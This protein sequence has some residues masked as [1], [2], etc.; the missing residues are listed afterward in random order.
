MVQK[1]ASLAGDSW[2]GVSAMLVALPSAIAFG[3]TIF[4]PLG[5]SYA[6]RGAIAGI[7]GA[8]ALGLVT[9]A[10]GGASRLIS[11][12]CAPAAAVLSALAIELVRRGTPAESVA[13][14]LAIVALLTGV[15][16]V[17]FGSLGFGR[18]IK[19]MP[20]PVMSGYMSGVGLLIIMAQ[21]PKLL[22]AANG[23][24][25]WAAVTTPAGWHWHG[26]AVGVVTMTVM[27][28]APKITKAM[29]ATIL[30]LLAGVATY[31]VIALT[32][33]SMLSLVGNATVVG[34]LVSGAAGGGGF[35]AGI[36]GRVQAVRT[37]DLTELTTL[38]VPALSLAVLLSIDAL[39][40]CVVVDAI[41]RSRHDSN[42]VLIGQGFGNL[43]STLIGGVP[44][45]GTMG[46]T[47]VN[48]SSGATTRLSGTVEGIA[49]LVA[50]LALGSLLAWIPIAALAGI[51]IVVGARMFDLHALQF[52]KSRST[53]LDFVVIVTVVIVAETVSLIAASGAGI[54]LA[55]LLFIRE[56][57][58]GSVVRRKTYGNQLFS[59][60][61]RLPNEVQVLEQHGDVT[62]ILELQGSLFFGT[63]DQLYTALEPELKARQFLILDMRRVNAVD[64]TA[65]HVLE[66]VDD[67]MKERHAE[68]IFS[69]LPHNLPGGRDVAAYLGHVGFTRRHSVRMFGELDNALEWVEEQVIAEAKLENLQR[70]ALALHEMALFKGRKPETLAELEACL[71]ARTLAAGERI[72]SAGETGDELYL[73]RRGAVRIVLPIG[74]AQAHHVAT[75]RRA[76]FF[77]EMGFLDRAPRSADAVAERETELFVLKR[78]RFD[79]L[80]VQHHRLAMSVFEGIAMALAHRLRHTNMELR[81]LEEA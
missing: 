69:S 48:I 53:I 55:I 66:L 21:L 73:I 61:V 16:Q 29:P 40:T 38:I 31:F 80:A 70:P 77:G 19:Y 58:R 47:L 41:T 68:L 60:Q 44:G 6:A 26:I 22:G 37:L 74:T 2:G 54:G 78:E 52:L 23:A 4:A 30:G 76:D 18:L 51:L 43:A 59:K 5:G 34:P 71:E 25:L 17:A 62:A 67:M 72:F 57:V 8:T 32:D 36:T 28:L 39:K 81:S 64:V 15:L 56:Q 46:P 50:F 1:P 63:A 45:S 13:L 79:A 11:A 20:Y 7:L 35:I 12:P 14:M 65:A 75:F 33:R 24:H 27:V 10:V 9:S 49:A 3:V 42:R